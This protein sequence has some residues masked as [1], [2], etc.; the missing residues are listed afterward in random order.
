MNRFF[1]RLACAGVW[2]FALRP[3][4]SPAWQPAQSSLMTQWASNVSPDNSHPEYPRP[5]LVRVDWRNLNGLWDYAVCPAEAAPPEKYDGQILVP[6]PI[7]SA[8]SGVGKPLG[9]RDAL[10]YRRTVRI[11]PEWKGRRVRLQFGAADWQ[12]RIMVNGREV[13]QHRGGY[14][15]FAFD[16]TDCLR[17]NGPEEIVVMDTDPTE[18][19]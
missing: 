12:C 3:G 14:D 10:W 19:R 2:L 17:W 7:E 16:I 1:R 18:A 9:P 5:Q 8:L 15:R 13:G 6:F 4:S 11:P